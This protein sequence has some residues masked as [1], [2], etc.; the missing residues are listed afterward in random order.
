MLNQCST[1]IDVKCK[2]KSNINNINI[3]YPESSMQAFSKF[4]AVI[5][6]RVSK[7]QSPQRI[8]NSL[9][10]DVTRTA[11]YVCINLLYKHLNGYFGLSSHLSLICSSSYKNASTQLGLLMLEHFS[12][13][14]LGP[15]RA[16]MLSLLLAPSLG[17]LSRQKY[18]QL[19]VSQISCHIFKPM[20]S[21]L[22]T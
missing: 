11:R 2:N 5:Y 20:Y 16:N 15:P 19:D 4:L 1:S 8:Q 14:N 22:S 3:L 6:I 21:C 17:I 12:Y 10:R 13:H 18:T 9:A 7:A